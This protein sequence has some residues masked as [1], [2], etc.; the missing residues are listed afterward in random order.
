VSDFF[1]CIRELVAAGD[2]VYSAHAIGKLVKSGIVIKPLVD[3]IGQAVVVEEYPDYHAGPCVLLLQYEGSG[4]PVHVL[5]GTPKGQDR[6][7]VLITA[8]RPEASR[9]DA[10]FTRRIPRDDLDVR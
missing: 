4:A 2:R 1:A 9:W 10:S 8:Y 7:A 3:T 6:P 5:W